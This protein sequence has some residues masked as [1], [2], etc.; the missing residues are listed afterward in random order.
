MKFSKIHFRALSL[1]LVVESEFTTWVNVVA[2]VARRSDYT[3]IMTTVYGQPA[4]ANVFKH[5]KITE[6]VT[7][8]LRS[9]EISSL[10]L[11]NSALS[12]GSN[13]NKFKFSK[14][15]DPY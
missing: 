4:S 2:L 10:S 8:C 6:V 11:T 5:E 15:D 13:Q 7:C 12:C 1:G 3:P 14:T 9:Y